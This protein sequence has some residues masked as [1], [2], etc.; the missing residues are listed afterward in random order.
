MPT[1][2][3]LLNYQAPDF[4]LPLV[5]GNSRL[6]LSD[7]R[8]KITVVHF[9]SADCPWSRRADLVL[10]YRRLAWDRLNIQV[11]GIACN[12]NET[13]SGIL[14]EMENRHIKYPMVVDFAQDISNTYRIEVTPTFLVLDRRNVVRYA[15]A[16]DDATGTRKLPKVFY[17]DKAVNA[18]VH[19]E[20]PNPAT[21]Q[22]AGTP[23]V[24]RARRDSRPLTGRI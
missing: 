3:D 24:R 21:T 7:L 9:W 18:A 1:V 20:A 4:A 23:L 22:A 14:A 15:G 12:P 10:V 8:N 2:T 19:D 13:E 6:V 16:L 17:L 11:V 5:G